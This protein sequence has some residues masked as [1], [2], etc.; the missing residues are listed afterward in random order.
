MMAFLTPRR[1]GALAAVHQRAGWAAAAPCSLHRSCHSCPAGLQRCFPGRL[2][3]SPTP[4]T[5]RTCYTQSCPAVMHPTS[6]TL[7]LTHAEA[8]PKPVLSHLAKVLQ[9]LVLQAIPQAP[10]VLLGALQLLRDNA[11]CHA[12]RSC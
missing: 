12:Q 3:S 1:A 6:S 9:K 5:P 8:L 10:H 2:A 7:P 4:A 11:C